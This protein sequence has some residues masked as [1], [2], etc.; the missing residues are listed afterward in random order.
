MEDLIEELVGDIA[1]EFDVDEPLFVPLGDDQYR[2]S[3]KMP[4]DELNGIFDPPFPEGDWNTVGGFV[5]HLKGQIPSEGEVLEIPGYELIPERV[6][7]RRIAVVRIVK[8][9]SPPGASVKTMDE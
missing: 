2:V 7:R 3:G 5:L 1:D 8:V 6:Q 4:I 9:T